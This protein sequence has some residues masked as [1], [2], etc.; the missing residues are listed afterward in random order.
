MLTQ[1]NLSFAGLV[2]LSSAVIYLLYLNQK[3]NKLLENLTSEASKDKDKK[4]ALLREAKE[5]KKN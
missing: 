1:K 5:A 4:Y 3:S 2:S